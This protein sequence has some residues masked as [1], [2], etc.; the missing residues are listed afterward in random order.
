MKLLDIPLGLI[1][2]FH[3]L[4]LTESVSRLILDQDCPNP[5]E[6]RDRAGSAQQANGEYRATQSPNQ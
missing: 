3:A 2:N 4:N 5:V 6:Q 1:I